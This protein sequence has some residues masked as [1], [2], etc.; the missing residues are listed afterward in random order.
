MPI[1]AA[2]LTGLLDN[3]NIFNGD[4]RGLVEA[5]IKDFETR[6][7]LPVYVATENYL[8]GEK[9]DEYGERLTAAW[10]K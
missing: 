2:P 10:L 4:D 8:T 7:G 9:V 1:P 6:T 5:A 3:G